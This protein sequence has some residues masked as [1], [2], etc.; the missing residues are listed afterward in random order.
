[1]SVLLIVVGVLVVLYGVLRPEKELPEPFRKS[2]TLGLSTVFGLLCI[3]GA[4]LLSGPLGRTGGDDVAA[5]PP[6][7]GPRASSVVAWPGG[8]PA[9]DS[10]FR[11]ITALAVSGRYAE[12]EDRALALARRPYA[13]PWADSLHAIAREAEELGLYAEAR[14]LPPSALQDNWDAYAELSRR[15]PDSPRRG[16]YAQRREDYARRLI[17][18]EAARYRTPAAPEAAPPSAEA[19]PPIEEPPPATAETPSYDPVPPAGCCRVCT[20]G[21][22]CGDTCIAQDRE[23]HRPPG[24][25]C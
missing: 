15:F 5:A 21:K 24:C 19:P 4:A 16:V 9:R 10:A 8:E 6:G 14:R 1:M 2:S 23:C 3:A 25:A 7:G 17:E 13:A 20:R 18:R 11:A 22:P 12:A